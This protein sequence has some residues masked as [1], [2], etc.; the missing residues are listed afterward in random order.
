MNTSTIPKRLNLKA[1]EWIEVRSREE[2]LSTLDARGCHE[3]T[4]FMPEMLQYCGRKFRVYRRADKTCDPA[5]EP[6]SI[7]RV[8]DSVHLEDLRCDGQAHGGCQAGCLIFWKEIW[9][10]RAGKDVISADNLGTKQPPSATSGLFTVEQ[11]LSANSS[12]DSQGE[13]V[14]SCQAT[15][16]RD[17]TTPMAA[18]DPRQYIRDLTSG[19]LSTGLG[20]GSFGNRLLEL[21]LGTIRLFRALTISIFNLV[22]RRIKGAA[23][24]FVIGSLEKTPV[25]TLNLQPGE[26]VQVRS[27]EEIIATLDKHNRNRGMLFDGEMLPYCGGLYRVLRRVDHILDE[28]TGKMV[29]MKSPCIILDGA[30]CQSDYHRLC[31]RAIYPYWRENWLKRVTNSTVLE[32]EKSS[33]ACEHAPAGSTAVC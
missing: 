6:W 17:Y 23:Y 18:W 32:S 30:V 28:R 14:Y 19:N 11:L 13:T 33:Q 29:Y 4:P 26:I 16:I 3:S 10:K 12:Q 27:K 9:L 22:P 7:R 1:G 8:R 21:V 15:T 25:E 20:D 31:P 24:P 5:H 2:V